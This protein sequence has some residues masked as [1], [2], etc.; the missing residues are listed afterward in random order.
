MDM[1]YTGKSLICT[2]FQNRA[3][4]CPHKAEK[5]YEQEVIAAL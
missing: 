4:V 3:V 1:V 5:M 2:G